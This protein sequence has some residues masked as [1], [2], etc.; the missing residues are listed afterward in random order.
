M[1]VSHNT[2]DGR[3]GRVRLASAVASHGW[4]WAMIVFFIF[5]PVY[6]G[7]DATSGEEPRATLI[8]VNGLSVLPVLLVP[9]VISG[10]GLT[11]VLASELG[12]WPRRALLWT[13]TLLLLLFCLVGMLSIGF[14]YI[15]AFL[16]M[17]VASIADFRSSRE[18]APV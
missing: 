6:S 17:L 15:P 7:Y 12:R 16:A 2:G 10:F 18:D 9:C 14:F 5:A 1:Q 4:T 11:A 13:S 3:R 8:S